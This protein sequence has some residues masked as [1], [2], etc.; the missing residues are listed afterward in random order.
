MTAAP[1]VR[2]I[3]KRASEPVQTRADVEALSRS[4]EEPEWLLERRL[5]A[6]DVYEQTPMPTL[7]DE[8]WRRTSLRKV[9]WPEMAKTDPEALESLPRDHIVPIQK[10]G[11]SG[12]VVQAGPQTV[13]AELLP[14]LAEKGVIFGDLSAAANDH[15]DLVRDHLLTRAVTPER[16]KF[17][18]LHAAL[19]THGVFLYVPQGVEIALPLR[20]LNWQHQPGAT[21]GHALIILERG[22]K[23]LYLRDLLSETPADANLYTSGALHVDATEAFIED[24]AGLSLVELQ[25]WGRHAYAFEHR[26][27]VLGRD[28]RLD[29]IAGIMGARLSKTY[30]TAD[31]EGEGGSARISGFYFPDAAGQHVDLDTAQNHRASHTTS[32]LLFKGPLKGDSRSVWRG[33]ITVREGVKGIDG[34][35]ANRNLMLSRSARADAIPG[36]EIAADDVRCSHAAALGRIDEDQIFYLTSRGIPRKRAEKLIVSGFFAEILDRIPLEDVRERA[37]GWV[38]ARMNA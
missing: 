38:D 26:R 2:R 10:S 14:E 11:S 30:L 1:V 12:L 25:N 28:S 27:A 29:W 23:A 31:L 16:G 19:W 13:H 15:A 35:Q 36:L 33:M 32:D 20:S 3:S 7:K 34:F 37:A 17:A 6:W 24:G 9:N 5:A 21:F 18:A 4:L 8:H 22:A